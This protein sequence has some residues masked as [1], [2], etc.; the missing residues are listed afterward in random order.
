M[1]WMNWPA[2]RSWLLE[3][4]VSTAFLLQFS[5][6]R[7]LQHSRTFKPSLW[8]KIGIRALR[9]PLHASH[10]SLIRKSVGADD[11]FVKLNWSFGV[12]GFV[13]VPEVHI[14]Q[15]KPLWVA[16]I[17]LKLVQQRPR[18]VAL[19]ISSIFDSWGQHRERE[20]ELYL[21]YTKL[22]NKRNAPVGIHV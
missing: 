13:F 20:V 8:G 9:W 5:T 17:P 1:E 12:A 2:A 14:V 6:C 18:S 16:F 21:N 4:Q 7:V 3:E 10:L 19:H 15:A 11:T 22:P